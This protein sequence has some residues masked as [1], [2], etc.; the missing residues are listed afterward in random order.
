MQSPKSPILAQKQVYIRIKRINAEIAQLKAVLK[1]EHVC[2]SN[3]GYN[4]I[5]YCLAH[6]DY[7]LI[8][9]NKIDPG[10]VGTNPYY[11]GTKHHLGDA[12]GD[13]NECCVVM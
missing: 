7:Y 2:V 3:A 12:T 1:K 10:T 13:S 6:P 8:T 5:D 11:L 9:E 4:I